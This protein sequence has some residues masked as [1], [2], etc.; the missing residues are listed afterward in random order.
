MTILVF[1]DTH[2]HT[3][4]MLE[5]IGRT[6]PD[7]ILHLGD[8]DRDAKD[9]AAKFPQIPLRVVRGNCDM[10]Q[11]NPVMETFVFAEQRIIMTHGHRHNVKWGYEDIW[12]MGRTA[13]AR[14]LL[15]GHTHIPYYEQVGSMHVL[16][17]GSAGTGSRKS[18][19]LI[20]MTEEGIRCSHL[21]L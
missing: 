2:G 9:V 14:I 5:T 20:R 17:P 8:H 4:P 7:L 19:G 11:K 15:F 12:A 6:T 16:N 21:S 1:S 18:A 3:G 10:G 13:G